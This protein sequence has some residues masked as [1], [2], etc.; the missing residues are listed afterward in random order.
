MNVS[1]LFVFIFWMDG[2]WNKNAD[3]DKDDNVEWMKRMDKELFEEDYVK[4]EVGEIFTVIC[5]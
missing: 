1:F 4:D 2:F 3:E 5:E